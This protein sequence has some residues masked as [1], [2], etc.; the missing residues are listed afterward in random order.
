MEWPEKALDELMVQE[1]GK[2]TRWL[3]PL[4][5]VLATLGRA[6]KGKKHGYCTEC[7]G[8]GSKDVLQQ[9]TPSESS[10]SVQR[11]LRSTSE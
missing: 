3:K 8:H 4:K 7:R 6:S 11:T 10:P 5:Q 2:K 1:A 9:Q